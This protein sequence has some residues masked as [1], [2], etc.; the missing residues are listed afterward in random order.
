[1]VHLFRMANYLISS[2]TIEVFGSTVNAS[3]TGAYLF[4]FASIAFIVGIEKYSTID[5]NE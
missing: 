5:T 4:L 3:S 1:M 2:K